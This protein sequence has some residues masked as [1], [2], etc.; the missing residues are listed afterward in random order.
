MLQCLQTQPHTGSLRQRWAKGKLDGDS[1][2]KG[3]MKTIACKFGKIASG[4]MPTRGRDRHKQNL[5]SPPNP[6]HV[7]NIASA[8]NVTILWGGGIYP[9]PSSGKNLKYRK[10][11]Y[12]SKK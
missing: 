8:C 2:K 9:S 5:F 7:I 12:G 1:C 3:P 4:K 6:K 11:R 10:T